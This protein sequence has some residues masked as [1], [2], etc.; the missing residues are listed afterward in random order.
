MTF[1]RREFVQLASALGASLAW[2]GS[3]RASRIRWPEAREL[4]PKASLQA[5]PIQPA[6]SWWVLIDR[7]ARM[8]KIEHPKLQV[9]RASG[10]A[11]EHGVE[12]RT[13]EGV[14]VRLT[15]AAKTVADCFRYRRHV[16]LDVALAT[17]RDYL[18]KHRG[19]VDA[20]F[21]AARADRVYKLMRPYVE[22]LV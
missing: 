12:S 2:S 16:G 18:R 13:I 10:R 17:L 7:H 15:S 3:A 1:N 21:E 11:R 19:G 8:P 22:A 9:V 20:L 5:I 6:S 14:P 4:Y